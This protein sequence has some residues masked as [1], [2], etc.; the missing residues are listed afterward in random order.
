MPV[1]STAFNHG[2]V[3]VLT[4]R[5]VEAVFELIHL[6]THCAQVADDQ[7][8]AVRLLDAQFFRIADTNAAARVGADGGDHREF[9]R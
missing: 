1:V 3:K 8:D 4:A 9:H 5:D 6:G 7:G 2:T